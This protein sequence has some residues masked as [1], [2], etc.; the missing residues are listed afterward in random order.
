ME[1]NATRHRG[2]NYHER[3]NARLGN[4]KGLF[5]L[6]GRVAIVTGVGSGLGQGIA[7]GYSQMG[8]AV[9]VIDINPEAAQSTPDSINATGRSSHRR[10]VRCDAARPSTGSRS[11]NATRVR[12][13]RH[14]GS[15]CG[16]GR[17]R[18]GR[19]MTFGQWERVI[20]INLTGVWLFDQEV[21]RHMIKRGQSHPHTPYQEIDA[22][23]T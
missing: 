13:N 22:G 23:Q 1:K 9:S 20:A 17:P 10:A 21:G 18:S 3:R 8:A 12:Q 5:D 7:E 19:G 11:P 2:T 14:P 4:V 6:T 16:S 15:Q